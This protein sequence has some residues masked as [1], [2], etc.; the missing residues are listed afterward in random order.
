MPRLNTLKIVLANTLERT[1]IL[2]KFT[3]SQRSDFLRQFANINLHPEANL[4]S[5]ACLS[6]REYGYA[7]LPNLLTSFYQDSYKALTTKE[8]FSKSIDGSLPGITALKPPVKPLEGPTAYDISTSSD[9]LLNTQYWHNLEILIST[10]LGTNCF[11]LRENPRLNIQEG[12]SDSSFDNREFYHTDYGMHQ[13]SLVTLLNKTTENS[14]CTEVIPTTHNNPRFLTDFEISNRQSYI[15]KAKKKANNLGS[16]KLFGDIGTTYLFDA[17]NLLHRA[18]F[19]T[20]DRAMLFFI[21]SCSYSYT[22]TQPAEL[23]NKYRHLIGRKPSQIFQ[24]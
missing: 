13:L 4:W 18:S 12:T 23:V 8:L 22:R 9:I 17:G 10:Y 24:S 7:R 21:F 6:M 1:R 5:S 11:W 19:G 16:I 3:F 2:Y 14:I 15:A 20:E